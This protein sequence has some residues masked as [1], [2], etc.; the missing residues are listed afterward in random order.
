VTG[1]WPLALPIA[2]Q[3]IAV[4]LWL[5]VKGLPP[6]GRGDD[7]AGAE[8]AGRSAVPAQGEEVART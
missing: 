1:Y 8:R 3:E 2:V 5:L 4:A 6:V 7:R